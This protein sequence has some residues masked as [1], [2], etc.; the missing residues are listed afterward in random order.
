VGAG[1]AV[2]LGASLESGAEWVARQCG[3]EKAVRWADLVLTGEGC[4]DGQTA[5]GKVPACVGRMARAAHKPVLAL[6]GRL[7]T[8]PASL[9]RIGLTWCRQVSPPGLPLAD[10]IRDAR[11]YLE[12]AA[13]EEVIRLW[14]SR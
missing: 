7:E 2:F 10:C 14:T 1:L 4:L 8:G 5:Y 12:A 11:K 3:L 6:A 13:A 9:R